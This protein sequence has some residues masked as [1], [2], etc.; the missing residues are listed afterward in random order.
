MNKIKLTESTDARNGRMWK[1][2]TDA[3]DDF[4]RHVVLIEWQD[5]ADAPSMVAWSEGRKGLK[6]RVNRGVSG[7]EALILGSFHG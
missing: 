5:R 3:A 6:D 7:Y 1:K 4:A 2:F